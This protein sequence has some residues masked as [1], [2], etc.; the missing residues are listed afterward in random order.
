MTNMTINR[1]QPKARMQIEVDPI[2]YGILRYY[3]RSGAE[4]D[5]LSSGNSGATSPD[6]I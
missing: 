4:A 6:D 1:Q 3:Q 2:A 5:G